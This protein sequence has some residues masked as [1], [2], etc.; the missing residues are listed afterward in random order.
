M[1]PTPANNFGGAP[2]TPEIIFE[3]MEAAHAA[4]PKCSR[5]LAGSGGY[6]WFYLNLIDDDN[7]LD[8]DDHEPP[9]SDYGRP[10]PC[11]CKTCGL[12][13][14]LNPNCSDFPAI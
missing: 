13:I 2:E 5:P 11:I 1:T 10:I 9:P 12:E 8:E 6:H 14:W 4:L 3:S 7:L